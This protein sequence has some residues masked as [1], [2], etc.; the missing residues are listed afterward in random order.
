M[1]AGLGSKPQKSPILLVRGRFQSTLGL[2]KH[3]CWN[4]TDCCGSGCHRNAVEMTNF[5]SGKNQH[6]TS[7]EF[8]TLTSRCR[9]EETI[10]C[11]ARLKRFLS[12]HSYF[13]AFWWETES[14]G[15]L[16]I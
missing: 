6:G 14:E 11:Q 13:W 12:S 9:G 4:A 5:W 2:D 7:M 1:P 10:G 8:E 3:F 16:T 15:G